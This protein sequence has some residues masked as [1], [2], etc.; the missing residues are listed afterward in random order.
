MD[1][2]EALAEALE[3]MEQADAPQG[4]ADGAPIIE[5]ESEEG[6]G[7]EAEPEPVVPAVPAVP[8]VPDN[9]ADPAVPADLVPAT[10]VTEQQRTMR[11]QIAQAVRAS[12][13]GRFGLRME[14]L[15]L[16]Q[17]EIQRH[18]VAVQHA[19]QIFSDTYNTQQDFSWAM[20]GFNTL[21]R[22]FYEGGIKTVDSQMK[23]CF[24]VLAELCI[25][26]T[27]PIFI[28]CWVLGLGHAMAAMLKTMVP[29]KHAWST[30]MNSFNHD[31]VPALQASFWTLQ[32]LA[33]W[34]KPGTCLR[35]CLRAMLSQIALWLQ[36]GCAE[37]AVGSLRR[38]S[39][40]SSC[41]LDAAMRWVFL[42]FDKLRHITGYHV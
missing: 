27:F 13:S 6:E 33:L 16:A 28:L 23:I 39:S 36:L 4:P 37:I 1:V 5:P 15:I 35:S 25:H 10:A 31:E 11:I 8:A 21:T 7:Q 24:S 3:L 41:L 42:T 2:A 12:L 9:A 30:H 26:S 22:S 29:V 20:F 34:S 32:N 38:R 18:A 19:P 40:R 17:D 14:G